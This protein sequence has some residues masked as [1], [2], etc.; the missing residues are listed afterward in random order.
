MHR[1][2]LAVAVACAGALALAASPSASADG[3]GGSGSSARHAWKTV[4]LTDKVV[5]PFHL[6]AA[7][8]GLYVADGGTSMVSR[9]KRD[10][11]LVTVATGPQPGEVPGVAFSENGRAMAYVSTDYT[12][13]AAL[14]TIR[15]G[16]KT[17]VADLGQYEADHNPDGHVRY[18]LKDPSCAADVLGPYASYKGM[19]ESHPYAVTR[20]N[21]MWVVADAA[22]NDLLAVTDRGNIRT[23]AVLPPQRLVI[24]EEFAQANGVPDCVGQTYKFEPVPTDVEAHNGKLYVSL[25]PGGPEDPSAGARGAVYTVNPWTGNSERYAS[26]LA[27]ATSVT[28]T[29]SGTVFVAELFAGRVSR[30]VHGKPVGVAT[31]PGVVAV[32]QGNGHLYAGLLGPTDD[33]GNPTGPGSVVRL[34]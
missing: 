16:G 2:R 33:Q 18:G 19:V 1:T 31:L 11:S 26:G 32:E 6:A 24:S 17:V 27:G 7:R 28:V 3:S 13:G 22:G 21:G 15:S 4:T 34:R 23:L 5:A 25:L 14:L 20:W 8:G 30:I 10:G 12:T 9:V 29:P